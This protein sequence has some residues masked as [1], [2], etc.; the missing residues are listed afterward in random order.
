MAGGPS[1]LE[2]FD[3]NPG[4]NIAAGTKAID[5]A[6][7]GVQLAAGLERL[8]EQMGTSRSSARSSA[9]RATTSAAPTR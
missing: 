1:Q 8:A 7:K 2:T 4:T 3:P 6:V 9:R 5:T